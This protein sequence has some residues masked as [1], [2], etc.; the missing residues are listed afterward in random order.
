MTP[1]H[2]RRLTGKPSGCATELAANKSRMPMV[3]LAAA[4]SRSARVSAVG[5]F[6]VAV[7]AD[8]VTISSRGD[9]GDPVPMWANDPRSGDAAQLRAR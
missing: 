9:V 1:D 6:V 7:V 5:R 3:P 8:V 4:S 2:R